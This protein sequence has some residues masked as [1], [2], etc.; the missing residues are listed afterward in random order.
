MSDTFTEGGGDP[1]GA[2][3]ADLEQRFVD[4]SAADALDP[5]DPD[6]ISRFVTDHN[7]R[8]RAEM[9]QLLEGIQPSPAAPSL[10]TDDPR[11]LIRAVQVESEA[12]RQ[13]AERHP[14]VDAGQIW[15]DVLRE[16]PRALAAQG[17]AADQITPEIAAALADHLAQHAQHQLDGGKAIHGEIDRLDRLYAGYGDGATDPAAV[18]ALAEELADKSPPQTPDEAMRLLRDAYHQINATRSVHA[19]KPAGASALTRDF[20]QRIRASLGE[21]QQPRHTAADGTPAAITAKHAARLQGRA[22]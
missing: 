17:I 12:V 2:A 14:D 4:Q 5:F 6:S 21:T 20:A 19:T 7:E 8:T 22:A 1:I 16:G 10:E 3:V 9:L 18:A 11:A 15:Q 13:I